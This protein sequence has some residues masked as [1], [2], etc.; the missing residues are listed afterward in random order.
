MSQL[1]TTRKNIY[2]SLET[3]HE[4]IS[5]PGNQQKHPSH[6]RNFAGACPNFGQLA[7]TCILAWKS[8]T[9]IFPILETKQEHPSHHSRTHASPTILLDPHIATDMA[10]V[11][12]EIHSMKTSSLQFSMTWIWLRSGPHSAHSQWLGGR[13]SLHSLRNSKH[14]TRFLSEVLPASYMR[15]GRLSWRQVRAEFDTRAH[16]TRTSQG[17]INP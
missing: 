2:P 15:Q 16:I 17:Q 8:R 3:S 12:I 7:R 1:W 9:N 4:Y 14:F 13:S 11:T 10:T 5:Y 6:H